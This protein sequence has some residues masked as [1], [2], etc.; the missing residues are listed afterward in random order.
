M[1]ASPQAAV[2]PETANG[3]LDPALVRL[4]VILLTGAIPTLLD[5]SIV[6]VAIDTIGRDLHTTVSS[7]QWLISGECQ[8]DRL[9]TFTGLG[10]L[11]SPISTYTWPRDMPTRATTSRKGSSR[12]TSCGTWGAARGLML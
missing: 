4:I 10:N 3:K 9:P 5:T 7:I 11:C 12:G 2:Q 8:S 1:T 6:N